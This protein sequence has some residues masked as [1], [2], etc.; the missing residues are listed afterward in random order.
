MSTLGAGTG[1]RTPEA[2]ARR[3]ARYFSGLLW[4]AGAF[5]LVNAF[6]WLLDLTLAGG[7][8]DW[9]FWIT[10]VWGFALTFHALAYYIDGRGL[11][12]RKYE[13]YLAA[14]RRRSTGRE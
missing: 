8:L 3:R 7:G 5:L 1:T 11:E 6:F 12:E 10:A 4:H 9:A 14:A 13:Q 2:R